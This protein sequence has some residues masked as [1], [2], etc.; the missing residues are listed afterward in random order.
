VN[1]ISNTAEIANLNEIRTMSINTQKHI[2]KTCARTSELLKLLDLKVKEI[3][4]ID[5]KIKHFLHSPIRKEIS[6]VQAKTIKLQKALVKEKVIIQK[7]MIKIQN[8]QNKLIKVLAVHD[9]AFANKNNTGLK[10]LLTSLNLQLKSYMALPYFKQAYKHFVAFVISISNRFSEANLKDYQ[11]TASGL[12]QKHWK[13]YL[14]KA[15]AAYEKS[16]KPHKG[17]KKGKKANQSKK[18]KKH[19]KLP[20]KS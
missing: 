7:V 19:T 20:I 14:E 5:D 13:G 12:I 17:G 9:K 16:K 15:K 3:K 6:E 10:N 1:K 2:H 18:G 8:K 4:A 11:G